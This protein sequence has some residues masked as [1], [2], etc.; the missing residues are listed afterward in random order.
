MNALSSSR[1]LGR[2]RVLIVGCGDVGLRCLALL[3]PRF[4]VFAMTRDPQAVPSDAP[5]RMQ[6]AIPVRA[7]LDRPA[8]LRR[9]AALAPHI[10][11]LAPPPAHGVLDTR[12][13]AL[14]AALGQAR[15]Q[16][17][18]AARRRP[19]PVVMGPVQPRTAALGR[20]RRRQRSL[21]I[22][23]EPGMPAVPVLTYAS[24]SGVYGDCAGA[25]INE[26]RTPRPHNPRAV[27]RVAAESAL[28]QAGARGLVTLRIVRIPGIYAA[29][30]LPLARL[31]KGTPALCAA[32][33]VY[34][35]HIHADD[36]ARIMCRTLGRGMPQRIVHAS[37]DTRLKMGE[38]FDLVARAYGLPVPPR[39]TRAQ[40]AQQLE[41]T[42][43][44]FMRESRRLDNTRLKRELGM[45]LQYPS[46]AEFLRL[47]APRQAPPN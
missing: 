41:P 39:I 46:V 7:D 34:T 26:T 10:L 18:K 43:L 30:R 38:Y 8:S 25:L 15:A 32:D 42:L 4:R 9:I 47:H 23:P 11:H 2:P 35:N 40:A 3:A 6:G 45:R 12:T 21:G 13:R 20:Q 16:R 44:S 36:L 29:T 19:P 17:T 24:T 31:H 28:R 5:Q 22:V 14:L 1:K 37:D 27:R 33:D